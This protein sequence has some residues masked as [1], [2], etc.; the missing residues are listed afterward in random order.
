MRPS[1]ESVPGH[2]SATVVV[3]DGAKQL[4]AGML[5]MYES[6]TLYTLGDRIL[7]G[8]HEVRIAWEPTQNRKCV[9]KKYLLSNPQ[10]LRTFKKEVGILVRLQHPNIVKACAVV[11]RKFLA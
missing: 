1:S 5:P 9:L 4:G 11:V 10:S 3:S 7:G 2:M 8:T 6:C